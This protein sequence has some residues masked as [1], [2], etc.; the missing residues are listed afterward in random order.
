MNVVA[1]QNLSSV[2]NSS[3][4][5]SVAAFN[6]DNNNDNKL[7]VQRSPSVNSLGGKSIHSTDN[8][9]EANSKTANKS[10]M[11]LFKLLE[12]AN[13]SQYMSLFVEQ[14]GDDIDQLLEADETEFKEIV[15]LVG[16]S[17]KPLHVKRFRK[18]IDEYRNS[19]LNGKLMVVFFLLR[20]LG[21]LTFLYCRMKLSTL[22]CN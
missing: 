1:N 19:K 22:L 20:W 10:E 13:L 14:G 11:D 2:P 5:A 12:K 15:D 21:M 7:Q 18:A 3:R 4:A 8:Q 9:N 16:M 6:A 17:A